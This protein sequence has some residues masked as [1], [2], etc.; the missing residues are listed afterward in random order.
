MALYRDAHGRVAL[1]IRS[2]QAVHGEELV[3][4]NSIDLVLHMQ[5]VH[6]GQEVTDRDAVTWLADTFGKERAIAATVVH[7]E[8]H[9][10]A[11]IH[12]HERNREPALT[13][14]RVQQQELMHTHEPSPGRLCRAIDN[15]PP[16]A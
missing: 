8:Q 3:A 13:P 7:T 14:Q 1:T 4:C 16:R 12:A 10:D 2:N 9:A 11:L 15:P 6:Q 5:S